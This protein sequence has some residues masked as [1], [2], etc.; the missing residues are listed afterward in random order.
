MS[1]NIQCVL[2]KKQ[3]VGLEKPPFPGEK[4]LWI[5]QNVSQK[6]WNLWLEHQTRLINEKHLNLVAPESRHYLSEQMDLFFSGGNID[7]VEGYIPK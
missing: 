1:Q 5:Y 3:M 4:G 2:L 7:Q 6:A